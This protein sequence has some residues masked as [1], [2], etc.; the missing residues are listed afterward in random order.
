MT[1]KEYLK[2]LKKMEFAIRALEEESIRLRTRME[3]PAAPKYSAARVQF[4]NENILENNVVKLEIIEKRLQKK[5]LKYEE[6]RERIIDEIF[7][8]PE[9]NHVKILF[10][11]Y[12]EGL[13]FTK[14]G[15]VMHYSRSQM[16]RIHG[17]A[18]AEFGKRFVKQ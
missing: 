8:L 13:S 18:L 1:A 14:T 5:I 3:T 17:K 6:T 7:A 11:I 2:Q 15:Y 4:S 10:S 12:V 9:T 16:K